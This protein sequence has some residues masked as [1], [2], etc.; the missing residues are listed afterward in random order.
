MST[1]IEFIKDIGNLI[2]TLLKFALKF[3]EDIVY[4]IKLL[5]DVVLALP[6]YIG[7]LPSAV[8]SMFMLCIGVVVVYKIAGRD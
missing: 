6:D 3:V 1:I 2:A 5:G 7:F 4:I 8:G